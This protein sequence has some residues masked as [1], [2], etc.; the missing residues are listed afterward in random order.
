MDKNY[1]KRVK[2]RLFLSNI[3]DEDTS[4]VKNNHSFITNVKDMTLIFCIVIYTKLMKNKNHKN[5]QSNIP[6]VNL[7]P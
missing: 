7:H 3:P 2:T 6:F 4:T 5:L 1:T